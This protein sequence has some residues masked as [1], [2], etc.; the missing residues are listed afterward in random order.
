MESGQVIG[1]GG[2]DPI[3][4]VLAGACC[5]DLSECAD[6]PMEGGQFGALGEDGGELA[7]FVVAQGA[8]S[9]SR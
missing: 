1:A 2:C 7:A 5:E 4:E 8:A 9:S 3:F 6:V